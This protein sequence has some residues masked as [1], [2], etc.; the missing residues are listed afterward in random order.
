MKIS[1]GALIFGSIVLAIAVVVGG[2]VWFSSLFT[3]PTGGGASPAQDFFSALFPFGTTT[4]PTNGQG[5]AGG[6]SG[7]TGPV[8]DL[9]K[10]SAGPIGGFHFM[11]DGTLLYGER[12]TGHIYRTTTDSLVET[13]L[14]NTTI[15]G[16]HG[17]V[18]L[19][20]DS[21]ALEYADTGGAV[22]DYFAAIS[23]TT[24]DQALVGH[25]LPPA[26]GVLPGVDAKSYVS[27]AKS[28]SGIT[29]SSAHFD[30][31][32]SATLFN[33]PLKSWT[34]LPTAGGLYMETAPSSVP[35]F[36]YKVGANGALSKIFGNVTGLMTTPDSSGRY[37]AYSYSQNG[38][39]RLAVLDTKANSFYGSPVSTFAEKCA[40]SIVGS[41]FLFC[42]VPAEGSSYSIEQWYAGLAASSDDAVLI[43]PLAGTATVVKQLAPNANQPIDMYQ[44]AVSPDG[45]YAAFLNKTDLS[46]WLL[47]LR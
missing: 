39:L 28:G 9:R 6:A 46:L 10:V 2:L 43:D 36:L 4:R 18:W 1:R 23:T 42:G 38:A 29:V 33:S 41:P 31:T 8:P 22:R 27:Y 14:T 17:F 21:V 16:I 19:T 3:A 26:S 47:K 25:F 37:I 40:W 20:D 24:P 5:G 44:P 30:G 32:A 34:P 11:S 13:R 45:S 35:G 7:E 15:P 12:D